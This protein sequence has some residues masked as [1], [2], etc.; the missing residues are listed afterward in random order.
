[1]ALTE[2]QITDV[3]RY[4]GFQAS[5][6][7]AFTANNDIAYLVFGTRQMSLVERLSTL[8]ASEETVLV[9]TYLA[10]LATLENAI[11]AAS[12]NLDT[13]EAAVWKHNRNEIADREQWARLSSQ[14]D[15]FRNA[16]RSSFFS[17]PEKQLDE[18]S[19]GQRA[20]GVCGRVG[21]LFR[22]VTH[23]ERLLR[24]GRTE[25]ESPPRNKL[26]GGKS[27]INHNAVRTRKSALSQYAFEMRIISPQSNNVCFFFKR[28]HQRRV[29][30]DGEQCSLRTYLLKNGAAVPA[31]A[32]RAV[33][34]E[35]TRF[36]IKYF[37][38]FF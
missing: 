30:V 34:E 17:V 26:I 31:S 36:R 19:F 8:S 29:Q 22:I 2:A 11:V 1:M 4:A 20:N 21:F 15:F 13:D 14:Y 33:N 23:V 6:T 27:Q 10:N 9:N 35:L 5:G 18:F 38:G 12:A 24:R 32:Q 16:S 28:A 25:T 3:R 37:D 7:P